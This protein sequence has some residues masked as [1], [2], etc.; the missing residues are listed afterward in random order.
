MEG[1]N[2]QRLEITVGA[3]RGSCES[4]VSRCTDDLVKKSSKQRTGINPWNIL[5]AR[6]AI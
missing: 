5:K 2:D 6:R 4:Q 1:L 3:W